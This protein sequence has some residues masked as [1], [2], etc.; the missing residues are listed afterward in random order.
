MMF[1][2]DTGRLTSRPYHGPRQ[3][4]LRCPARRIAPSGTLRASAMP[5]LRRS[6]RMAVIHLDI[7]SRAP[8]ADGCPFG[9]AGAYERIDGV[10][11]F[12]VEPEHE[13]NRA[14]VDLDRALRDADGRVR[15]QA[16]FCL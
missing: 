4:H 2:S 7:Q 3:C 1:A 14:I 5:P 9:D 15:F 13:A 16:D 8:Y 11:H 6:C 10:L 12:A